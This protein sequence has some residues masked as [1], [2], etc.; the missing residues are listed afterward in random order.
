[1]R[2]LL[3][4][5]GCTPGATLHADVRAICRSGYA[6]SVRNVPY[7]LKRRIYYSYGIRRHPRGTY[8][9]DHLIPLELGGAN[10][11]SNLWPEAAPGFREK[12]A[13]ENYLHE[14]LCSGR[15]TLGS[16]QD[17]IRKDW[18][19]EWLRDGRP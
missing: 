8:E 11:Q 15:R 16:V 1:M 14:Q 10:A 3:P 19:A 7:S 13:L 4:D 12:D 6:R 5:P 18:H 9:I 17:A 2:G